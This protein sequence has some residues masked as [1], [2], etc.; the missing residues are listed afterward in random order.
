M[1]SALFQQPARQNWISR[2]PFEPYLGGLGASL[3]CSTSTSNVELQGDFGVTGQ[4]VNV[5]VIT[6]TGSVFAFVRLGDVNVVA[7][8]ACMAVPPGGAVTC[9]L[10]GVGQPVPMYIAG[11]TASGAATLQ[12]VT[13]YGN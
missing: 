3:S 8:T 1:S 6:N 11:I 5:A 9:S 4:I 12:I 10:Y 7:T 2:Y 13:G